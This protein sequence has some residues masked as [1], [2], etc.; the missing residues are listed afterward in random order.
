MWPATAPPAVSCHRRPLHQGVCCTPADAAPHPGQCRGHVAGQQAQDTKTTHSSTQQHTVQS[1]PAASQC[2][3]VVFV[4]DT[5]G[6]TCVAAALHDTRQDYGQASMCETSHNTH[7]Q[8]QR[9]EP[10]A[11]CWSCQ[12]SRADAA[13][14]VC[15]H[16]QAHVYGWLDTYLQEVDCY[17]PVTCYQTIL[18]R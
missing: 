18:R 15:F 4:S 13:L 17:K 6:H 10:E 1:T 7:S 2:H 11:P 5:K 8:Q 12:A 16:S 3:A 14:P 9:A